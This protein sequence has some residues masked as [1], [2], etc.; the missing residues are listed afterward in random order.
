MKDPQE[1]DNAVLSGPGSAPATWGRCQWCDAALPA[2]APRAKIR[3]RFCRGSRCR[4]MWH[5]ARRREILRQAKTL[6][7]ELESLLRELVR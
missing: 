2:P 3:R 5:L 7:D 6:L 1:R 4:S